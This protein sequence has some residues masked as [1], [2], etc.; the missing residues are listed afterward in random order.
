MAGLALVLS[1][2]EIFALNAGQNSASGNRARLEL[3][4]DDRQLGSQILNQ[5]A[6]EFRLLSIQFTFEAFDSNRNS[7][8]RPS[9]SAA[10]S[11]VGG[12]SPK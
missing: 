4:T 1:A 6:L 8:S 12:C 9:R 2:V 11:M 10:V 3:L 5:V 7:R